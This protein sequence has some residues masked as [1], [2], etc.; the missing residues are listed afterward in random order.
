MKTVLCVLLLPV[1]ALASSAFDGT[2]KTR[3]D[4]MKVTGTPDTFQIVNGVYTCSTCTPVIRVRTD[5][6]PH[7]VS[8]HPYYDSV[9]VTIV[10]PTEVQI[11]DR[12]VGREV[13]D[14]SYSVSSDGTTLTARLTD[15]T[16]AQAAAV[17]F[18]AR[19]V[20]AAPPG[21]HAVSGSWQADQMSA[22]NDA[23]RTITFRMTADD[24]SMQWNGQSYDAKFDG[25]EYP[26]SGDPG[27]TTVSLRRVDDRTVEETDHRNGQVT[28]EIRL[29]AAA[30]GHTLV[31]TDRDVQHNQ[32]TT[33]MLDKEP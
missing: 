7:P 27:N 5:G 3:M 6:V 21:A 19:R 8:G 26:V 13:Y 18:T 2:W 17:A 24:F 4:S 15:H 1:T 23:L 16:G 10:N 31:I 12:Q 11:V 28:D 29:S 22:A 33:M 9:A 20:A 30:D 32:T 14:M 25:A